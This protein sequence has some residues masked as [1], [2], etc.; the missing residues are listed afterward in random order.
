MVPAGSGAPCF[1][2]KADLLK[3]TL[4]AAELQSIQHCPAELRDYGLGVLQWEGGALSR[5]GVRR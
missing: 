3:A 2:G 5:P 4:Q 1:T